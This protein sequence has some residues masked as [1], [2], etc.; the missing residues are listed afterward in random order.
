MSRIQTDDEDP[1]KPRIEPD[2]VASFFEERARRIDRLGPVRAVLYQD[3]HPDLAERR[4]AAE[5]EILTPLLQLHESSRL[6]DIGCGTGRWVT[7]V[8]H[9]CAHYHGIDLSPGLVEFASSYHSDRKNCRFTVCRATDVS[10]SAIDESLPFDRVL[11]AGLFIYMNDDEVDRAMRGIVGV[12]APRCRVVFREPMAVEQR[13]TLR[14][15]FSEDLNQTYNAIYR[16]QAELLDLAGATLLQNG[17]HVIE[18]ADLYSDPALNNRTETRQ[19][20][21]VIERDA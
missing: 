18:T 15:H 13:L 17:F 7:S 12:S 16:T 14:D 3:N 4:D 10:L 21:I 5:R 6:L 19:R 20:W 9:S 1:V 11:C 2:E 8:S